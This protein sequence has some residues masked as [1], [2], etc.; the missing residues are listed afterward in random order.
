VLQME[1]WAS[2]TNPKECTRFSSSH[3]PHPMI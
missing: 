1:K 3:I 2:A